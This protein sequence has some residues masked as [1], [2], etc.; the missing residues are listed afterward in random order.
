VIDTLVTAGANQVNGPSFEVENADAALDEARAA[1]MAKARARAALYARAAGLKVGRIL[2]I[3]ENGGWSPPQPVMYR[4]A[5]MEAA[6]PPA[7]PVQA[8]EL[9]MQMTVTVQFELVP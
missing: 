7:P 9:Q 3:S 4:M 2:S 5:A 8:G 1:A 6:P